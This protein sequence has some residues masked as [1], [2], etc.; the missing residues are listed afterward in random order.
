MQSKRRFQV[1]ARDR[2]ILQFLWRWK[3][4]S[5][6]TLASQRFFPGCSIVRGYNRL[7]E[8][9]KIGLVEC[10]ADQKL[11]NYAWML[12]K[13]GFLESV[14]KKGRLPQRVIDIKLKYENDRPGIT[15]YKLVSKPSRALY[16]GY[17]DIKLI[18]NG[19]GVGIITTPHGIMTTN[20]ARKQKVGGKILFEIW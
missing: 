10:H 5:T 16:F 12:S 1:T 8:L 18:K 4:A 2:R 11:L 13:K 3:L 15:D 17:K 19:F 14:A 9:K 20:D 7:L 6:A